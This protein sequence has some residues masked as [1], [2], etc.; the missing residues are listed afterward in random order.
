[1]QEGIRKF[2][3]GFKKGGGGGVENESTVQDTYTSFYVI[4]RAECRNGLH[5]HR[6]AFPLVYI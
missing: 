1:M 3:V 5:A 6:I 4:V 2:E